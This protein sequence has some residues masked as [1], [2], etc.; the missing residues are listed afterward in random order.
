MPII[1]FGFDKIDAEKLAK[2]SPNISI[3]TDLGVTALETDEIQVGSDKK[4]ILR[5][6]FEFSVEYAPKVGKIVLGGYLL[7]TDSPK[8]LSDLQKKWK[9]KENFPMDFI[10]PVI[11]EVV[12][13]CNITALS[14][15]QEVGLPPHLKMPK[16]TPSPSM[17]PS[18][19]KSKAK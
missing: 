5:V 9:K 10:M 15:S 14:L 7:Y 19:E 12:R 6:H 8:A 2:L 1:G 17:A 4:E 18:P 13:K 3:K 16:L 11:N